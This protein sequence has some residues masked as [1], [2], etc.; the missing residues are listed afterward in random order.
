M[1]KQVSDLAKKVKKLK[2]NKGKDLLQNHINV[3]HHID[4]NFRVG[5]DHHH[6][7]QMEHDIIGDDHD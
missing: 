4:K 2:I 3:A 5:I 6:C 7:I 1:Q